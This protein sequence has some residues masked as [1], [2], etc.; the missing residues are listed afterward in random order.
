MPL[1]TPCPTLFPYLDMTPS[2]ESGANGQHEDELA[3]L[4]RHIVADGYSSAHSCQH[5][6]EIVII[7]W[8]ARQ[9]AGNVDW[10]EHNAL[11]ERIVLATEEE[12]RQHAAAGC[13]FWSMLSDELDYAILVEK[14]AAFAG[15]SVPRCSRCPVS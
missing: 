8:I 2:I 9:E 11:N 4:R 14:R 12:M 15:T 3:A 10:D 7:P 13:K 6:D 5:C 1:D